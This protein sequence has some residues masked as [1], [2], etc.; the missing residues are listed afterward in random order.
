MRIRSTDS[1]RAKA[2]A[3][4]TS[5]NGLNTTGPFTPESGGALHV[6]YPQPSS[7]GQRMT[8]SATL[9]VAGSSPVFGE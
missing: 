9:A 8:P 4:A 1:R 3:V 5:P 2:S 6:T 7:A